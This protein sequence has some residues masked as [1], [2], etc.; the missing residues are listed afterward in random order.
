MSLL[1]A[2]VFLILRQAQDEGNILRNREKRE[3]EPAIAAA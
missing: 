3:G 1:D 2:G